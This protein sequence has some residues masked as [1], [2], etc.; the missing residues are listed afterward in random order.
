M[1]FSEKG[2][3]GENNTNLNVLFKTIIISIMKNIWARKLKNIYDKVKHWL[4]SVAS[5]EDTHWQWKWQHWS[6]H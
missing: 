1:D 3:K 6:A 2:T 5:I 4:F